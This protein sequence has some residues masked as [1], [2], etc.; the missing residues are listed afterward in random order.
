VDSDRSPS[1]L[2]DTNPFPDAIEDRLRQQLTFLVEV[3]RLKTVL[4]QSPLAAADR[5]ENDAEHSWHLAMLVVVL[6]EYADEPIDIRRTLELV[7]LH[8]LV[9]IQ[10]GDTPLYDSE[11]GADQADRESAAAD[12]LFAL[13]PPDQAE[14]FRALWDEFEARQTPEARFAK[15]MDRLQPL[16][17]NWMAKGGTWQ[18]P[19]VTADDVRSRKAVIGDASSALWTAGLELIDEG[20]RRGWSRPGAPR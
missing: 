7:L 4:R 6:A 17:L 1:P 11:L 3:D 19:G 20:E 10:A 15:A 12:V 2:A 8:D 16:M 13:L 9:E 14:R 18:T 5:R